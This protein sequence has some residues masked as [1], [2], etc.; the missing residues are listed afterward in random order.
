MFFAYPDKIKTYTIKQLELNMNIY[1]LISAAV[2]TAGAFIITGSNPVLGFAI[3]MIGLATLLASISIQL[4]KKD[5]AG[6]YKFAKAIG[7]VVVFVAIFTAI[8]LFS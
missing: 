8:Q 4:Y 3:M 6:F 7:A 1:T 2:M 5:K